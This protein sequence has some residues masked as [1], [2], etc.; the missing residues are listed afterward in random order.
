MLKVEAGEEILS[1]EREIE[2]VSLLEENLCSEENSMCSFIIICTTSSHFPGP[3]DTWQ[4]LWTG[5]N[6]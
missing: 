1:A 2:N 3:V 5:R 6:V 4:M